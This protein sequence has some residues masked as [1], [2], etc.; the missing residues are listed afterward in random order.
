MITLSCAE[1]AT[2]LQGQLIGANQPISSVST[3]SR[4]ISAGALF[5]ALKG[6]NY[7]GSRFVTDVIE[8]GAAAIIVE[9]ALDCELTQIVVADT[10]LALGQLG[11]A[12]KA[13]V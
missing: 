2:L 10:R 9:R 1:I 12:I 4:T 7:D 13:R 3:D 8:K 5:I 11:A 6:P